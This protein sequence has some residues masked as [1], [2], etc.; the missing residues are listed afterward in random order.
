[1]G[2]STSSG[3]LS[4]AIGSLFLCVGDRMKLNKFAGVA[5]LI[6][7]GVSA[8]A[9]DIYA[10]G[11]G[12]YKDGPAYASVVWSGWYAGATGGGGWTSQ[13]VKYEGNFGSGFT[14]YTPDPNQTLSQSGAFGG[15]ELGYNWQAGHLMYGL[16]T[17]AQISGISGSVYGL[18]AGNPL[19]HLGAS[20]NLDWFGTVRGRLGYS[21][22]PVLAYATGGFAFGNVENEVKYVSSFP[23]HCCGLAG[24]AIADGRSSGIQTGY[25]VGGGLEYALTPKLT[26]K[27]EYQYIDLGSHNAVGTCTFGYGACGVFRTKIDDN[28]NTVRAGINYHIGDTGYEPLK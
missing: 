1:M 17:D 25:A 3:V 2:V 4:S 11:D 21:F 14:P 16:E 13:H 26:V 18:N 22:G 8:H 7:T 27:A 9:G 10:P 12:G 19:D 5:I 24:A 28:Y 23:S 20:S 6:A 15:G